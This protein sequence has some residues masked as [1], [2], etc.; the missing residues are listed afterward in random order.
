MITVK[1]IVLSKA[2]QK[3]YMGAEILGI[4]YDG[5]G[6]LEI[7]YTDAEDAG[8]STNCYIRQG[9]EVEI[10]RGKFSERLGNKETERYPLDDEDIRTISL[11]RHL[12]MMMPEMS[13]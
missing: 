2:D 4:R 6:R 5:R 1:M 11:I 10:P 12:P 3:V 7:P 13:D 8:R 9:Y